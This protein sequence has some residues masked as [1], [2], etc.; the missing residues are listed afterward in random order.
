M[1]QGKNYV[2]YSLSRWIG[3]IGRKE[4]SRGGLLSTDPILGSQSLFDPPPP[5][6]R[7]MSKQPQQTRSQQD[8]TQL[9]LDG[10]NGPLEITSFVSAFFLSH[11]STEALTL[12]DHLADLVESL[13]FCLN[14]GGDLALSTGNSSALRD[15]PTG[16]LFPLYQLSCFISH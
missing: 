8:R 3:G 15:L 1:L 4:G 11:G 9:G 2:I 5:I 12:G 7:N 10:P 14:A 13:L 16:I 6:T